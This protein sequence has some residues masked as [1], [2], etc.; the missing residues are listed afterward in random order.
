MNI[1]LNLR[2]SRVGEGVEL[3]IDSGNSSEEVAICCSCRIYE[4]AWLVQCRRITHQLSISLGVCFGRTQTSAEQSYERYR[5]FSDLS[6]EAAV[7]D[8]EPRHTASGLG[9]HKESDEQV[10]LE[11]LYFI[12]SDDDDITET[13]NI[14]RLTLGDL[15]AVLVSECW[16][17]M[18]I[19]T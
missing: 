8:R 10:E 14:N 19:L 3:G 7:T 13:M 16:N 4:R 9:N 5:P 12:P 1:L 11:S 15:P 17:D 6:I 2:V 18:K